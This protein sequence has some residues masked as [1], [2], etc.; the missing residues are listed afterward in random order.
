[1]TKPTGEDS[2]VS[3]PP[4][5]AGMNDYLREAFFFRWNLLLFAGSAAAAALTPMASVLLPLVGAGE[6]TFLATLISVPRFRAAIDAKM[7]ALRTGAGR[8]E[9]EAAPSSVS[10]VT[11]LG[12]LPADARQRFQQLHARCLGCSGCFCACSVPG[13]PSIGSC[14]R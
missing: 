10:L 7:H 13:P 2:P 5:G 11:M 4:A 1:M 6:L 9:A 14:G 3:A 8:A 12:G